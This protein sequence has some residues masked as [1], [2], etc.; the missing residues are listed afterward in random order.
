M[1]LRK[2]QRIDPPGSHEA[3]FLVGEPL[4]DVVDLDALLP[5]LNSL[6]ILTLGWEHGVRNSNAW[7]IGWIDHCRVAGGSSLERCARLGGQIDNLAA[8]AESYNAPVLDAAVLALNLLEDLWNTLNG[9]GWCSSGGEELPK[10][11]ALLLLR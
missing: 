9:L 8:P 6:L 4:Y 3:V 7:R 2:S 10:L 11:L 5:L 1:H